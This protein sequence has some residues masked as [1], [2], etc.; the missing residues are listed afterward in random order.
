MDKDGMLWYDDLYLDIDISPTGA[1]NLLD[2]DELD[3]ALRM[4]KITSL[5]YNLA[6]NEVNTLLDAIEED[7][8]P[9]LWSCDLHLEILL[10]LV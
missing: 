5:E 1:T 7:N 4:E 10:K 2:A 6:W 9:L 8:F 3:D